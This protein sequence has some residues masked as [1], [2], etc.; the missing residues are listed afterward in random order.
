MIESFSSEE[1]G[2]KCHTYEK[3]CEANSTICI[4]E[5]SGHFRNIAKSLPR[6]MQDEIGHFFATDACSMRGGGTW[7]RELKQCECDRVNSGRF[8]YTEKDSQIHPKLRNSS[9]SFFSTACVI[10]GLGLVFLLKFKVFSFR[11]RNHKQYQYNK[12]AIEMNNLISK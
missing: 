6:M 11:N 12:M 5:N 8:C 1:L 9:A 4:Y 3:L 2:V 10:I 7:N